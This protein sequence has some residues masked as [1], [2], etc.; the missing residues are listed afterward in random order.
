MPDPTLLG[1]LIQ[2]AW[3][4]LTPAQRTCWHFWA[5]AHPQQTEGGYLFTMFGQQAHYSRNADLA[6]TE[7]ATLLTEPPPN[8]TPPKPVAIVSLAWPR[9]SLT[10]GGVTARQGFA[11]LDVSAALPA[12]TIVIVRQGYDRKK[13][14]KPR[15]PRIRHVTIIV[16]LTS[17]LISLVLPAGYYATTSGNTKFAKIKG[18]SA[19][20]RPDLPLGTIRVVNTTN[21][22]TIRQVLANPYG[23]SR[24]K[25]SRA[26]ASQFSTSSRN[27]FP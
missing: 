15:P 25:S 26:P 9:A 20:R 17:G 5:A 21:G 27:H 2:P 3:Q 8:T 7:T 16:P 4:A 13:T 11:V 6:V 14:G 12:D 23:G 18:V 19:K 10:V 24:T 1:D 22:E